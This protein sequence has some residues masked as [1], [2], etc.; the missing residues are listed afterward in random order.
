MKLSYHKETDSLYID[1][2]SEPSTESKE[3]SEGIVVDYGRDGNVVG[4]DIDN[5]SRKVDLSEISLSKLPSDIE[6]LTA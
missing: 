1:F 5:A 4:I 2:S 6:T 3:I